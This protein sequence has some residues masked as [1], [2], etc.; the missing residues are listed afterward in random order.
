MTGMQL[1][2]RKLRIFS[3]QNPNIV[4]YE[5]FKNASVDVILKPE[6]QNVAVTGTIVNLI[7]D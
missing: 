2:P 1:N 6:L 5:K 7:V 3:K 4:E